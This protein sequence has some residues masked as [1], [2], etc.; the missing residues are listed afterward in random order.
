[1]INADPRTKRAYHEAGE[2]KQS[3]RAE[4]ARGFSFQAC[5]K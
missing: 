3:L 1:M 4:L 2:I 5:K